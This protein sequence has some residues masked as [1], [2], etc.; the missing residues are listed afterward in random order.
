MRGSA[1]YEGARTGQVDHIPQDQVHWVGRRYRASSTQRRADVRWL[2]CRPLNLMDN[3][4]R[5]FLVR[6]AHAERAL[7]FEGDI[8]AASR[9]STQTLPQA[10]TASSAPWSRGL[11]TASFQGAGRPQGCSLVTASAGTARAAKSA[12]ASCTSPTTS[13]SARRRHPPGAGSVTGRETLW[14]AGRYL[15]YHPGGSPERIPCRRQGSQEGQGRGQRSHEEG[16]CW[17]GRADRDA[18]QGQGVLRCRRGCRR[19]WEPTPTSAIPTIC[20]RGGPTRTPTGF[21]ETGF[22]RAK[23]STMSPTK[24]R[25]HTIHST[26]DRASA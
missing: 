10:T 17:Q 19:H 26:K 25:G 9:C 15:P 13:R 3:P 11:S 12:Q 5:R 6:E 16:A 22:R 21:S 8:R 2:R 14:P 20:G 4:H 23:A 1:R 18:R 7:V 24:C